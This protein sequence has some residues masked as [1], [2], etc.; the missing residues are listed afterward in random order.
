MNNIIALD[1][2]IY[3]SKLEVVDNKSTG[4]TY[5]WSEFQQFVIETNDR[6]PFEEDVFLILQTNTDKIII[7]QSKVASDKAEKLFQHF[8]NFNF[9]IL[10]Q[11]MSSSQN[12][13]FICWNK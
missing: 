4:K 11:A 5:A 10:T 8:P 9:D 12:Q 6:G 13:Q 3:D 1:I 2:N 7:P